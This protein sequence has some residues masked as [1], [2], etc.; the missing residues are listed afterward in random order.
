MLQFKRSSSIDI[1]FIQPGD[2]IFVTMD[3]W[4]DIPPAVRLKKNIGGGLVL[5]KKY[6][7]VQG[8]ENCENRDNYFYS[9]TCEVSNNFIKKII[10]NMYYKSLDFNI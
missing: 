10:F 4:P 6:V 5:L 3:I 7:Y 9:G 8:G 2:E 1:S